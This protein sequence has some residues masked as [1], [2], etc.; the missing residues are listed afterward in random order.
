VGTYKGQ[1][2]KWVQYLEQ[3]LDPLG[4]KE[5]EGFLYFTDA[6]KEDWQI[7]MV[8]EPLDFDLPA[9]DVLGAAVLNGDG[10]IATLIKAAEGCIWG[11]GPPGLGAGLGRQ[12]LGHSKRALQGT[13]DAVTL[14]QID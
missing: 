11:V 13:N 4:G 8:V 14:A 9:D 3:V 6:I 12:R 2:W 5:T 1:W 10:Q 7:V